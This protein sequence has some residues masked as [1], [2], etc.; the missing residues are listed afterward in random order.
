MVGGAPRGLGASGR[1]LFKARASAMAPA[2][3]DPA[4]ALSRW[5]GRPISTCPTPI[6]PR[7][8]SLLQRPA[9]RPRLSVLAA[10]LGGRWARRRKGGRTPGGRSDCTLPPAAAGTS[11]ARGRPAL[12]S[13]QP[14][15]EHLA[16]RQR[17]A[18]SLLQP[19][20]PKEGIQEAGGSAGGPHTLTLPPWLS[21][22]PPPQV[23]PSILSP[24]LA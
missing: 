24:V 16:N 12:L 2:L 9:P 22:S 6:P 21:C 5:E 7:H 14:H 10:H 4:L 1:F 13:P 18:R 8:L 17:R 23:E 15:T 3:L 11:A 20:D 19:H